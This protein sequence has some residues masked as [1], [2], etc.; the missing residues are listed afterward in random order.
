MRNGNKFICYKYYFKYFEFTVVQSP[1][2]IF[3]P[4]VTDGYKCVY[5]C[6]IMIYFSCMHIFVINK[7][8]FY[9][10]YTIWTSNKNCSVI[11]VDF[12]C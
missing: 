2:G 12:A 11:E 1:V 8:L 5:F 6:R 7:S 9:K 10:F 3:T 4:Y